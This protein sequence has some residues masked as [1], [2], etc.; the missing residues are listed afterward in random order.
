RRGRCGRAGGAAGVSTVETRARC[1]AHRAR[2]TGYVRHLGG[3][4]RDPAVRGRGSVHGRARGR[5]RCGAPARQLERDAAVQARSG[6]AAPVFSL[7]PRHQRPDG[8]LPADRH[9][10][11]QLPA[12]AVRDRAAARS[13]HHALRDPSRVP[14]HSDGRPVAAEPSYLGESSGHWDG[15]TFVVEVTSLND[16]S[17]INNV[18]TIHT[19]DMKVTERYTRDSFETIRYE[20]TMVDPAVFTKP[21]TIRETFRLRPDERIREYECIESNEDIARFERLLQQ[22]EFPTE[23]AP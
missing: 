10:P 2:E 3:D 14:H 7:A 15:D 13:R 6:S 22:G 5:R 18:G 11:H 20:A 19:E 9:T 12:A 23:K 16:K 21:F 8:A 4:G 17:W 1:S